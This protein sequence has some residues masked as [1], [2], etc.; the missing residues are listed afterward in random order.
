[1]ASRSLDDLHPKVKQLAEK[2]L[3]R[4]KAENI[5]VLIYCTYRSKEE[6]DKLYA[7]GRTAP[8]PIVTNARGNQSM[9]QFRLA[10]DF[11][12]LANGKPAWDDSALFTKCGELGEQCGL[13][14]AGR[15][16]S[17]KE[18]AHLQYTGGLSLAD[19]QAGKEI[20]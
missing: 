8:G 13:E 18:L 10:F 15:W 16:K 19:L 11:T 17:F 9:H 7:Q 14:W 2:F 6:Q 4:C 1:M 12:P 20:K 3:D 5:D